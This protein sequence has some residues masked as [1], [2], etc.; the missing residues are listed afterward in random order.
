MNLTQIFWVVVV[1]GSL[2]VLNG[3]LYKENKKVPEP[4]GC[5]ELRE[6]CSSCPNVLCGGRNKGGE[7]PKES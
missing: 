6:A 1:L 5:E 2:V 7:N 4:K 3:F